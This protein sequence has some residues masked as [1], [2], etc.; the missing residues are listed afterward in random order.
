MKIKPEQLASQV[1]RLHPIYLITGDDPMLVDESCDVIRAATKQQ[2][3]LEREKHQVDKSFD[4]SAFFESTQSLSLFAEKRVIELQLLNKPSEKG[5]QTLMHYLDNPNPDIIVIIGAM[6]LDAAGQRAKWYKAIDK[7][8]VIVPIW[9]LDLSGFVTWL[10]KKAQ[11]TGLTFEED[12]LTLIATRT[13]G[14]LLAAK[15]EIDKLSLM[16]LAQPISLKAAEDAV[17]T[18][19]KYSAFTLADACLEGNLIRAL[20]I[21]HRLTSEGVEWHLLTWQLTKDLRTLYTLLYRA[22]EGIPHQ[23]T[24]KQERVL[25]TKQPLFTKA[26][27]RLRPAKVNQLIKKCAEIDLA[28]KGLSDEDTALKIEQLCISMCVK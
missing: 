19:S 8:G 28:I 10:R 3:F 1:K 22:K 6:K 21:Y 17:A 7:S 24:F 11:S 25:F 12:A 14:N 27:Q 23:Q 9:P 13:E 4:W 15:Q 2:G 5:T 16:S 18:T 20:T 26:L